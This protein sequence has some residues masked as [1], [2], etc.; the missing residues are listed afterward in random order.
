MKTYLKDILRLLLS[1]AASAG[2]IVGTSNWLE[3]GLTFAVIALTLVASF[4][5]DSKDPRNHARAVKLLGLEHKISAFLHIGGT[6][7]PVLAANPAVSGT[8]TALTNSEN[9]VKNDTA[10]I[11]LE[12]LVKTANEVKVDPNS[13]PAV[14]GIPPIDAQGTATS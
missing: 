1:S 11:V 2:V 5:F 8:E 9:A 3:R 6:F 14:N 10:K 12:D 7:F 4:L 13:K